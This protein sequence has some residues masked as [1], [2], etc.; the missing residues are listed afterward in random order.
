VLTFLRGYVTGGSDRVGL[1]YVNHTKSDQLDDLSRV[2]AVLDGKPEA[3]HRRAWFSLLNRMNKTTDG[4]ASDDYLSV[5]CFRNGNGHVTFKRPDLVEQMNRIL[6]KHFP[7][8]L[9]AEIR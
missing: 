8:A 6:A 5:R 2:C 4:P 7:G 9:P 3:D 1:G